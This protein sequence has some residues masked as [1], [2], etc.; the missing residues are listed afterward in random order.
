MNQPVHVT[1]QRATVGRTVEVS[2]VC[3]WNT[4]GSMYRTVPHISKGLLFLYL[5]LPIVTFLPNCVYNTYN[6]F[7]AHHH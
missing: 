2:T 5:V 7:C 3:I 6:G 4:A 1:V